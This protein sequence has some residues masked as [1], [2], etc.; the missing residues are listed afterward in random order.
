VLQEYLDDVGAGRVSVAI[1][2]VF[3]LEEIADA[4][5]TMETNAAVGKMVVRVRHVAG[6]PAP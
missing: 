6:E 4:H 3:N 5:R 1:H 2:R